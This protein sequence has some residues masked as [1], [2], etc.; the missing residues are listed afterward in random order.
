[1]NIYDDDGLCIVEYNSM[2]E[3]LFYSNCLREACLLHNQRVV[4]SETVFKE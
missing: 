4:L 1:M 2:P 3:E